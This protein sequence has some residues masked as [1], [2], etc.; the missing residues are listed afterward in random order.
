MQ[1]AAS[2]I[3][4]MLSI[5]GEPVEIRLSGVL[6]KTITGK[7]R[8]NYESVSPYESNVGM[9][10]PAVTVKT[11]DLSGVTNAHSFIVQGVEYKFDGKPEAKPSGLSLVRLGLKK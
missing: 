2:D 10:T 9:L 7:F 1:F 8:K 3:D 11:S 6:V 4:A 5:T